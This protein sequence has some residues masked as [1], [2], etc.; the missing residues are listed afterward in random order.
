MCVCVCACVCACVRVCVC[1]HVLGNKWMYNFLI[2]I[3][4][5][6]M[7]SL[8]LLLYTPLAV[9]IFLIGR[10]LINFHYFP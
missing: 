9:K 1:V 5:C 7:L 8:F 10:A 3:L 2:F 6:S 4:G